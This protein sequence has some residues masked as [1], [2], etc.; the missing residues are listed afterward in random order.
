MDL[1]KY[2]DRRHQNAKTSFFED[3]NLPK[4]RGA[5]L[6]KA[7]QFQ[8][9]IPVKVM[10]LLI[11]L[12]SQA[13]KF[14]VDRNTFNPVLNTRSEANMLAKMNAKRPGIVGAFQEQFFSHLVYVNNHALKINFNDREIIPVYQEVDAGARP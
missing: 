1:V 2:H 10:S 13:P 14:S 5:R 3:V 7:Q 11:Y 9:I 6:L 4:N 8:P 12:I